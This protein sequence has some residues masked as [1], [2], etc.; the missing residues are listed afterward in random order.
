MTNL[1]TPDQQISP[2]EIETIT[3]LECNGECHVAMWLHDDNDDGYWHN[4]C[5]DACDGSGKVERYNPSEDW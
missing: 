1:H 4:E 5:C 2:D 3:C